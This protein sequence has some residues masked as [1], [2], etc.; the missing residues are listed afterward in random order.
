MQSKFR[1]LMQSLLVLLAGTAMFAATDSGKSKT[2]TGVI[3]DSLCPTTHSMADHT[4]IEC[5]RE[6]IGKGGDYTLIVGEK[7]YTLETSDQKILD[8]LEK[9]SA[10]KVEVT[11]VQTDNSIAVTAVKPAH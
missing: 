2:F 7:V 1:R 6:C 9:E 10:N 11:G 4:D 8:T 3:G 5:I